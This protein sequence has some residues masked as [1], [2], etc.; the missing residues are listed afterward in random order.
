MSPGAGDHVRVGHH[1]VR[2]D[3]EAAAEQQASAALALDLDRGRGGARSTATVVWFDPRR[4]LALLNVPGIT[5]DPLRLVSAVRSGTTG[6]VIGY[7]G[8][9]RQAVVGARVVARTTA[10]GRDIYSSSLV[11]REI[12]VL[13]AKVRKGDSGGPVVDRSGRPIGVVFAA[14]TVDPNEGYALT[15]A[16]L[17]AVL[18][19]VGASRSPVGVS[20]CAA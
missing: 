9:G 8:G 15:N 14:S 12:Y 16:E 3:R 17:R 19:Q 20:K 11:R 7:P 18:N 13:R 2:L 5:L 6:A 4:D 1:Q 10:V